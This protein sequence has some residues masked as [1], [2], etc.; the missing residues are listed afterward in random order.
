M[1]VPSKIPHGL[2][3]KK[4]VIGTINGI[5]DY[6]NGNWLQSGKGINIRRTPSGTIIELQKQPA[7]RSVSVTGGTAVGA[8]GL[9]ATVSGGSASVEVSGSS[10]LLI[11][12]ANANIQI[13]GGTNGELRIGASAVTGMPYWLDLSP[14][15]IN[16]SQNSSVSKTY[17]HSIFLIGNCGYST[18]S[19]MT[20]SV[21]L[22]IGGK[23]FILFDLGIG[24]STLYGLTSFVCIPIPAN[25]AFTLTTSGSLVTFTGYAYS[26]I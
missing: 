3:F 20:G 7:S 2:N 21:S 8:S 14:E 19:N 18:S 15:F 5:I 25:T 11:E 17:N 23:T 6:L 26:T 16:V 13:S 22:A 1:P 24:T 4:A 9:V 12:P 10:P